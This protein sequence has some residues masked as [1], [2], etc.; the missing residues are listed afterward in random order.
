MDRVA[1][2]NVHCNVLKVSYSPQSLPDTQELINQIQTRNTQRKAIR[3]GIILHNE[4]KLI[5]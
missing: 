3:W 1:H 2:D 4:D 5:G